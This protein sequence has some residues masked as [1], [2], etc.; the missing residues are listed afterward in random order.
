MVQK[1]LPCLSSTLR[2]QELEVKAANGLFIAELEGS[3][4]FILWSFR[5][6]ILESLLVLKVWLSDLWFID[7]LI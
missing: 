7:F 2:A 3:D 4:W 5:E 6:S 1:T